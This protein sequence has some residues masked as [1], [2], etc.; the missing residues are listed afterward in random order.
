[1]CLCFSKGL[2]HDRDS[3]LARQYPGKDQHDPGQGERRDATSAVVQ[4]SSKLR[5]DLGLDSYAALEL[6]FELEDQVG[7]R[8]SQEAA[9]RSRPWATW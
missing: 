6:I 5:E 8:V 1:M 4:E 2:P 9:C 7:V 3:R